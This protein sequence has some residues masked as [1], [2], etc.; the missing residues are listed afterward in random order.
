M[1]ICDQIYI[2]MCTTAAIVQKLWKPQKGDYFYLLTDN[3]VHLL[4]DKQSKKDKV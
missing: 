1:N 2:E 4:T 3:K